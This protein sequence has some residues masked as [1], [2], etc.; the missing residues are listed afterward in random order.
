MPPHTDT[1]VP[2]H[3]TDLGV[4]TPPGPGPDAHERA[5]V[6]LNDLDGLGLRVLELN[7]AGKVGRE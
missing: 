6:A 1:R 3:H 5:D 7:D 4:E 2:L